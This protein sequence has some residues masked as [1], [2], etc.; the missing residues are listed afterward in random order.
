MSSPK[1]PAAKKQKKRRHCPGP[2]SLP[3]GCSVS[4]LVTIEEAKGPI[5]SIIWSP[6][7][8]YLALGL[9]NSQVQLWDSSSNTK[10]KTFKGR[11]TCVEQQHPPHNWRHGRQDCQLRCQDQACCGDLQRSLWRGLWAQVVSFWKA[12]S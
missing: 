6:D 5:T 2:H 10:I 12:A 3:L 8:S 9:N 7:A 11:I 4:E 1:P